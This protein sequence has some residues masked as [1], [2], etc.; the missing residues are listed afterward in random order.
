LA[1]AGADRSAAGLVASPILDVSNPS[2]P[3]ILNQIVDSPRA[4][5]QGAAHQRRGALLLR[6]FARGSLLGV[7][8]ARAIRRPPGASWA[9]PEPPGMYQWQKQFSVTGPNRAGAG[10][11]IASRPHPGIGP[12]ASDFIM[13]AITDNR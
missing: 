1:A 7:L 9:L 12:P 3:N 2:K 4:H 8:C 13:A 6:A 5:A 11:R 10:G